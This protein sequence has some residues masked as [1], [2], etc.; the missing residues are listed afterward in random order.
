MAGERLPQP[1]RLGEQRGAQII[2]QASGLL[3]CETVVI[4]G[5]ASRGFA[6]VDATPGSG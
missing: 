4:F 3:C 5:C 2:A 1:D 6:D